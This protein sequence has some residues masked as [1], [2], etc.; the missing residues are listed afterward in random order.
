MIFALHQFPNIIPSWPIARDIEENGVDFIVLGMCRFLQCEIFHQ[1]D[2]F[3]DPEGPLV[4]L[5]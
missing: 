5:P 3:F 2:L 1:N 4:T